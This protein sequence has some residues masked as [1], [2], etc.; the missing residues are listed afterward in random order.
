MQGYEGQ[1]WRS[2]GS[3]VPGASQTGIRHQMPPGMAS[4][5]Y[6]G[7]IGAS[8]PGAIGQPGNGMAQ[9]VPPSRSLWHAQLCGFAI[10]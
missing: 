6:P 1:R 9:R 3:P 7:G 2:V 4:K 8:S 10:S 5:W